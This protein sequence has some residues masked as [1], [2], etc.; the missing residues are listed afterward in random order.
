MPADFVK[1]RYRGGDYL[2]ENP[3]WDIEDSPWKA[4]Q[5]AGILQRHGIVPA[6]VVE[7]G[8]GAG[9]VLAAL[10]P[11]LPGARL[12]GYEI[13]ADAAAFWPR[14]ASAGIELQLGDFLAMDGG[15]Y[16]VLLLLDVLEHVADPFDF[17]RR[18]R[19]R[20]GCY[21]FHIP[22]DLS[23]ASVL[24]ETPLLHVRRKVGHIHY[25]TR[26]LALELLSECGYRV[27]EA[28]YTGAALSGPRRSWRTALAALPRR[29][30]RRLLGPDRSARLLGGE[31]LLVLAQPRGTA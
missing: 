20:A 31:T 19:G 24:R 18:L 17:L 10:R 23:A 1:D 13:A 22:L 8:C 15:R 28:S 5:V 11:F 26:G 9:G 7:V 6:S 25:F 3:T 14:H 4:G 27:L 16:D 21:V 12:V 30:A 2:G 29:I